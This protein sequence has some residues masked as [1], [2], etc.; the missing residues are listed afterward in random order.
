[1]ATWT[2][3][4]NLHQTDY[5]FG[6]TRW[7]ARGSWVQLKSKMVDR[8]AGFRSVQITDWYLWS[9]RQRGCVQMFETA[10]LRQ[11]EFLVS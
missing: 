10:K 4:A 7:N 6:V 5:V 2:L 1:M 3:Y 8:L 9:V 11:E